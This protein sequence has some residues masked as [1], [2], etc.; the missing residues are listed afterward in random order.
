MASQRRYT[1]EWQKI[2]FGVNSQSCFQSQL[3]YIFA[4]RIFPLKNSICRNH[5]CSWIR[6]KQREEQSIC[7]R[8][9]H[10]AIHLN[11]Y[12]QQHAKMDSY[13]QI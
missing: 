1:A 12:L 2:G 6:G 10:V 11:V 9:W 5:N 13:T 7:E 4:C 8:Q 3:E